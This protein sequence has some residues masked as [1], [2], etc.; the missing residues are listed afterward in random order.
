MKEDHDQPSQH[1][2]FSLG[3]IDYLGH[4]INN[5][6][7]EG[8]HGIDAAHRQAGDEVLEELTGKTDLFHG[9]VNKK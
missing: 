5:V 4:I 6:K 9:L 2:K 8:H 1:D 3:Q 7:P